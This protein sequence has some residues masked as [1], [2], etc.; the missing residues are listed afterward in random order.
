MKFQ[1]VF[2]T[3]EGFDLSQDSPK[4]L[5]T[6]LKKALSEVKQIKVSL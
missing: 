5:Y 3:F 2:E 1:K 4:E 6:N